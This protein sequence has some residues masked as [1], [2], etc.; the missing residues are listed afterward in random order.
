MLWLD[1]V[2]G[3]ISERAISPSGAC[4]SVQDLW[5]DPFHLRQKGATEKSTGVPD[6]FFS[7]YMYSRKDTFQSTG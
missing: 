7:T 1:T 6:V 5:V 3:D 4:L 2:P